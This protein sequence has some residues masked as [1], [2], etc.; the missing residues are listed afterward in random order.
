MSISLEFAASKLLQFQLFGQ[1]HASAAMP[2][3]EAPSYLWFIYIYIHYSK[4]PKDSY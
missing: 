1:I 4:Q 3:A 2:Q